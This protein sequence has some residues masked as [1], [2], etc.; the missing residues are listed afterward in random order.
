MSVTA[1]LTTPTTTK[2]FESKAKATTASGVKEALLAVH[3][4]TNSFLT[5]LV[6]AQGGPVEEDDE[7]KVPEEELE[8]SE[9]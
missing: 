2:H 9:V 7:D 6:L 8:G 4:D 3:K 1:S 5:E